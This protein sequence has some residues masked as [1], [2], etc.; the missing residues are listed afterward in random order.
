MQEIHWSSGHNWVQGHLGQLALMLQAMC[1]G[2][3]GFLHLISHPWPTEVFAQQRQGMVMPLMTCIS[4]PP[5]QSG[6][7]VCLG[8][9]EEQ[10]FSFAFRC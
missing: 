1:A 2:L 8:D 7:T 10:I 3:Q 6:N 9:H 5:I 4:V